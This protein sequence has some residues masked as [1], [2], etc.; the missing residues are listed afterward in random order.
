MIKIE[1]STQINRPVEEV[2]AFVVDAENLPLWAGPVTE[3]RQTSD[4]SIGVGTTQVQSAQFLGRKMETTQEVTEYEPN[5]KFST[6]ST[7]GPL[8]LEIH[9]TFESVGGGT[10]ITLEGNLEAG[11]FFKLAE[12]IV[13]RMLNRQTASDAQTLKEL[14]EAQASG[15]A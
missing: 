5:K 6:K 4:G 10:K 2:F 15:G 8:P 14:L 13:G 9:Y 1:N 3:A 12:P 7:S 11:G